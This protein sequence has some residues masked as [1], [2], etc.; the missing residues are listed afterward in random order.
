MSMN[1]Q[2]WG[3]IDYKD[4]WDKQTEIFEYNLHNKSEDKE[5][6]NTLILCEHPPVITLGKRGEQTNVLF[7]EEELGKRG[8]SLYRIDRG[9]DVTYH[10]PGQLVVYPIF[11]LEFFGIGLKEYIHRL[12]EVII[13]VLKKYG[14]DSE[15]SEGA[16]GVWLGNDTPSS[17]RKICAIGVRSSRFITMHGLALNV[18]TRLSDFSMIHPCGFIDKGVTSIQKEL[19]KEI[20]MFEVKNSV[21]EE[22]KNVFLDEN[23]R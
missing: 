17:S 5:T 14:I 12:E 2:D 11:D 4:A 6:I 18:N 1:I 10:G 22:F 9:G 7:N 23:I 21:I 13:R 15:R 19:G 3:I 20:N 16:T 8:V